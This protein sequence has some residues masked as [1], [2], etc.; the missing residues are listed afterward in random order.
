MW[1]CRRGGKGERVLEGDGWRRTY[2]TVTSEGA[3]VAERLGAV[4]VLALV[5]ALA[6]AAGS[7]DGKH[8]TAKGAGERDVLSSHVDDES[9]SL[10]EVA[11]AA[12]PLAKPRT[13]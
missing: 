3:R 7:R 2:S 6:G 1:I 5:R 11:V 8:R 4:L 12:V 13:A 10:D 9:A